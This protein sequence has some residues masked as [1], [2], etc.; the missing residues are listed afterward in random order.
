MN[1]GR[2]NNNNNSN[3]PKKDDDG[4]NLLNHMVR[5]YTDISYI[6]IYIYHKHVAYILLAVK[7]M[8]TLCIISFKVHYI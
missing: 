1:C 6:N 2:P 4:I 3:D 8:Y 5:I 7:Y